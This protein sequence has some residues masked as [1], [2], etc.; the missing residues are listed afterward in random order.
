MTKVSINPKSLKGEIKIPPSKSMSHRAIICAALA[1]GK[2]VVSNLIFSKDI[3]ASIGAMEALSA[4]FTRGEDF[5]EVEG[6]KEIKNKEA[7]IDCNESGSTIRFMIPIAAALSA[8]A[9]FVGQGRLVE[10]PLDL[11]AEAFEKKNM[12][13]NYSGRLPFEVNSQ[14]KSGRYQIRGDVSSQFISGLLFALPLL[15]GKSQ[16]DIIGKFESKAYVDLTLS[17]L[18][19]FKID[20]KKGEKNSYIIE[21]SQK[22]IAKDYR[23]EG[24]YSQGAFWLV[25]GCIGEGLLCKDLNSSS[26]QGDKEVVDILKRMGADIEISKNEIS[27]SRSDTKGTII[28]AAECP[29]LIPVLC[30][31]AALSEGES[32][33]INGQ[34]LRIK[35]S[36]RI[37]S[38]VSELSK[39]GADIVETEDGMIING[40]KMLDGGQVSSWNDHRIAMALAIASI[41][42]KDKVVIDGSDSVS[43]SYPN[44]FEDF[45]SLG[46]DICYG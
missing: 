15:D 20:I 44:F 5:L 14:L 21:G 3:E 35:E 38:T 22:Y 25:A 27:I 11:Y 13:Y 34:R 10:R 41:R 8:K 39:L 32:R 23:V 45:A 43:K 37:K 24:D 4:K 42:C 40:K 33:V 6:I 18:A 46:G 17:A 7:T 12:A 36:D 9:S 29:D 28:D 16:I 30:V 26:L 2:S 1:E 19:D 31:L